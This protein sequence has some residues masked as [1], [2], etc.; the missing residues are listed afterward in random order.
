MARYKV[1]VTVFKGPTGKTLVLP[2]I[3]HFFSDLSLGFGVM[4]ALVPIVGLV[5]GNLTSLTLAMPLASAAVLFLI[6]FL[7]RKGA[8]SSAQSGY[9]KQLEKLKQEEKQP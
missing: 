4:F 7:L 8:K 5:Q 9:L 6:G 3:L 1:S 2:T